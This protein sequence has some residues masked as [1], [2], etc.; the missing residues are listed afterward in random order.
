M[1]PG[2]LTLMEQMSVTTEDNG[3]ESGDYFLSTENASS[4]LHYNAQ[5][6]PSSRFRSYLPESQMSPPM[7]IC[8]V[9]IPY[10]TRPS[11][12]WWWKA[13]PRRRSPSPRTT[14]CRPS[15][16]MTS[17][18]PRLP[19][20]PSLPPSFNPL[21]LLSLLDLLSLLGLLGLLGLLDKPRN[22]PRNRETWKPLCR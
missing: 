7:P 2:G 11:Q 21:T 4:L 22:R 6:D 19:R 17:L 8:V 10:S 13:S 3:E 14:P 12:T 20:T 16:L 1:L 9:F 18:P 15:L 5:T